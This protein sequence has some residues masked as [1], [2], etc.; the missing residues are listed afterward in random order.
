MF[1]YGL[2]IIIPSI[3]LSYLV[4]FIALFYIKSKQLHKTS[5]G[6]TSLIEITAAII[7][8]TCWFIVPLPPI[9]LFPVIIFAFL[10]SVISSQKFKEESRNY[11]VLGLSCLITALLLFVFYN[12]LVPNYAVN[13]QGIFEVLPIFPLV[14]SLLS[15]GVFTLIIGVR[16]PKFSR[17]ASKR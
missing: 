14:V 8:L 10:C 3:L 16:L 7:Y 6:K 9:S 15:T 13:N 4:F 2:F 11:V 12:P 5:S 17:G 1:L